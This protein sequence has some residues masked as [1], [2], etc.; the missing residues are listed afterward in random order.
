L[1]QIQ[2]SDEPPVPQAR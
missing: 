1:K 2:D